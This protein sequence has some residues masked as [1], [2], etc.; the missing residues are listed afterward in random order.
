MFGRENPVLLTARRTAGRRLSAKPCYR[1]NSM[2]LAYATLVLEHFC[3][4][5]DTVL[6]HCQYPL[7]RTRKVAW[8]PSSRLAQSLC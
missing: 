5:D 6:L 2:I 4:R 3:N 1:T 7:S 8:F